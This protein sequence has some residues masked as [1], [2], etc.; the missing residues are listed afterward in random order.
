MLGSVQTR[1]A[2]LVE[3]G[4]PHE[5]AERIA[6]LDVMS[7]AM[8]I[9]SISRSEVAK[10]A[11]GIEEV[12]RVYFSVGARFGLDR[13]RAA[14]GA[15]AAEPR[16]GRK[17]G[18]GSGRRPVQLSERPGVARDRG[19][20]RFAHGVGPSRLVAGPADPHRGTARSDDQRRAPA[21]TV[22]LAMLSVASRQLRTL[23]ES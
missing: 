8:D 15:I 9:V 1:Q 2:K 5:L 6:A 23:A 12:A 3:L 22:D 16:R 20:K 7:S 21:P 13:L 17:R 18:G 14:G 10:A 11:S 4:I 19:R